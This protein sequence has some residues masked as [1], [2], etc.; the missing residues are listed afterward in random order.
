ML[1]GDTTMPF[2]KV[3]H[4]NGGTAGTVNTM[5]ASCSHASLPACILW[6]KSQPQLLLNF[7]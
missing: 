2:S 1:D 6:L 7:Q 4:Q 3:S 5:A